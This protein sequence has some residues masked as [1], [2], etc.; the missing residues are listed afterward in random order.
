M[1]ELDLVMNKVWDRLPGVEQQEKSAV[2]VAVVLKLRHKVR[3]NSV[4][5]SFIATLTTPES[6][7]GLLVVLATCHMAVAVP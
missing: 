7:R 5:C 6:V 2:V 3:L 1:T 4:L